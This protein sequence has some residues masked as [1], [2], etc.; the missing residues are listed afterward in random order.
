M[1]K[2]ILGIILTYLLSGCTSSL[3]LADNPSC[4]SVIEGYY[5]SHL[6]WTGRVPA[7]IYK[8][9]GKTKA[10]YGQ[11]NENSNFFDVLKTAKDRN[12]STS[13]Q[14][15]QKENTIAIIDSTGRI[16]YGHADDKILRPSEYW[17][18]VLEIA[19][20]GVKRP[21]VKEIKLVPGKNFAFCLTPGE[22]IVKNM[23]FINKYQI[24]DKAKNFPEFTFKVTP[25]T[26]TYIG[27]LYL[28]D[29]RF[30]APKIKIPYINI[31]NPKQSVTAGL[32]GGAIGGAL[33]AIAKQ[34]ATPKKE[35]ILQVINSPSFTPK[36]KQKYMIGLLKAEKDKP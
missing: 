9:N 18:L 35:H 4:K 7:L 30:D 5:G 8:D 23:Y 20:T 11:I 12:D 29:N 3:K 10:A 15:F 14:H 13:L 36:S 31:S 28:D 2:I 16:I 26:S 6:R 25:F 19:K 1:N 22:Y 27:N 33:L 17:E 24:V 21:K 34:A 32:I